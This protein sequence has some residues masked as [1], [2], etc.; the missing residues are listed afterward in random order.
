MFKPALFLRNSLIAAAAA[1]AAAVFPAA[2]QTAL[3]P[4][5]CEKAISISTG[6]LTKYRGKISADL[7]RSFGRFRESKCDLKTDFTRVQGTSDDDAFGEFRVLLIA[8]KTAD[9]RRLAKPDNG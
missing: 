5:Q 6:I 1:T 2:A 8:L 4:Q 7:A 3:T 9:A